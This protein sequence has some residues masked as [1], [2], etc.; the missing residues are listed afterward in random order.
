[1]V[2]IRFSLCGRVANGSEISREFSKRAFPFAA[3]VGLG[4]FFD[5]GAGVINRGRLGSRG[6][7]HAVAIRILHEPEPALLRLPHLESDPQVMFGD[8]HESVLT[9]FIPRNV[10]TPAI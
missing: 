1:M 8:S 6:A 7:N 5:R 3:R 10:S 9:I 4:D 2:I